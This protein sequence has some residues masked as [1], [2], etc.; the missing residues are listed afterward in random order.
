MSLNLS[1]K[2]KILMLITNISHIFYYKSINMYTE[3]S[4]NAY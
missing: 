3:A 1:L 2:L 4:N